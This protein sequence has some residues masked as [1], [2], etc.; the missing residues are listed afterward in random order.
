MREPDKA[1]A[2]VDA[3]SVVDATARLGAGTIIWRFCHVMCGARIGSDCSLGQGCFVGANVVIGDRVRIQN[4][5][6]VF[7][8]VSIDDDVFLGPSAVFTNVKN[9]RAEV[10]RKHALEKTRVL[11][12][13]TV[14]AN[15]TIVAG[16]TLGHYSFVAAGAVVT[17]DVPDFTLVSGVPARQSGFVSRRGERLVFDAAGR[18]SCPASGEAYRLVDGVVQP[19]EGAFAEP[20][21][22]ALFDAEPQHAPL[23]HELDAALACVLRSGRFV[24]GPQLE[25]F[26]REVAAY[27]G[28]EHAIGV[29][30]GSDALVVALLALGVG[31]GDEV[32]TTPFSFV[33]AAEAIARVGATPRFADID[34]ASLQLLPPTVRAALSERTRA[35]I[36]VHLYGNLAPLAGLSSALAGSNA[37]LVEDAAQA[38]GADLA[39]G[40]KVGTFGRLGCFSFFPS[41][42]L[43]ALGDAGLVV[44][45]EADLAERA[46]QARA[47]GAATRYEHAFV[48]GNFRLD[49]IQAAAL[50]VKLRHV[51]AWRER[52]ANVARRYDAAFAGIAE[53]ALPA[54]EP[55]CV[56]SHGLYTV[57][58]PPEARAELAEH[59]S[60]AGIATAIHY[61]KPLHLQRA[62]AHLG[63]AL[64]DFPVAERAASRVL[65]LPIHAG[66]DEADVERVI[67]AVQHF[68]AW[69]AR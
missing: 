55:G 5:V 29:S 37:C 53:L 22:V 2:R 32:I 66:L 20:A 56:P 61:P 7:E 24:M 21:A 16:V 64:G 49:E 43:G 11:K 44:T 62:F 27:L 26:E 67:A 17:R 69:R 4:N 8:G 50:R 6:S 63:Y 65:S 18:A 9:P 33:A 10:S 39:C 54:Q 38:F 59:L 46:R 47:H 36:P 13:A 58:V 60:R 1:P 45:R 57:C 15:A 34:E 14:G 48:S 30:S 3:S 23:M 25:A 41:K 40:G 42:S 28:V 31:P 51:D 35:V 68:F 19:A 12:G 52:R